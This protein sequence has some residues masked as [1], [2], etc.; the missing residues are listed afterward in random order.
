MCSRKNQLRGYYRAADLWWGRKDSRFLE[1]F[2]SHR[3]SW[4]SPGFHSGGTTSYGLWNGGEPVFV[5]G[6]WDA[7]AGNALVSSS[8][9][10]LFKFNFSPGDLISHFVSHS[11][12]R[13]QRPVKL[14][15]N[16]FRGH[17]WETQMRLPWRTTK[18]WVCASFPCT[19]LSCSSFVFCL[20]KRYHDPQNDGWRTRWGFS[21]FY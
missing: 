11:L 14:Q 15:F 12:A 2:K 10:V 9:K 1:E 16:T 7:A 21:L 17:V 13:A 3:K 5:P 20:L 6:G 4:F 18:V 19:A 8:V